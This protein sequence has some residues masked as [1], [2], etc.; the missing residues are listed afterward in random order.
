[1]RAILVLV[2]IGV[3]TLSLI[4]RLLLITYFT[5]VDTEMNPGEIIE[6]PLERYSVGRPID[7]AEPAPGSM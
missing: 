6:S 2:T 3:A 4:R 5:A 7:A 1:V